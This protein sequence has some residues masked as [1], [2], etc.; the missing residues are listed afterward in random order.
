MMKVKMTSCSDKIAVIPARRLSKRL[1]NK[2]MLLI[3]GSTL[4]SRTVSTALKSSVF[5]RIIISTDIPLGEMDVQCRGSILY[6]RRPRHLCGAD[7]PTDDVIDYI[8]DR[9]VNKPDTVITLL[10][11]TSPMRT[12]EDIITANTMYEESGSPVVSALKLSNIYGLGINGEIKSPE[13]NCAMINGSI[14]VFSADDFKKRQCIPIE[15]C[16]IMFMDYIKSIDIDREYQYNAARILIEHDYI[17]SKT[18]E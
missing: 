12:A 18:S 15:G 14:Y 2:N 13:N 3:E 5:S 7:T 9:Y 4:V 6:D 17:H 10:Q 1:K 8:I 11:P 16:S